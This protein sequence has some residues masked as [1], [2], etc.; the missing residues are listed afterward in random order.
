MYKTNGLHGQQM[1]YEVDVLDSMKRPVNATRNS[2]RNAEGHVA[3]SRTVIAEEV[4]GE[5]SHVLVEIPVNMLGLGE[6]QL[7]AFARVRLAS[8]QGE[9]AAEALVELPL[10]APDVAGM[11]GES[12]Y[13]ASD[14]PGPGS[15]EERLALGSGRDSREPWADES[16]SRNTSKRRK[17]PAEESPGDDPARKAPVRESYADRRSEPDRSRED[18]SSPEPSRSPDDD[19]TYWSPNREPVRRHDDDASASSRKNGAHDDRIRHEAARS[20]ATA[21]PSAKAPVNP[22]VAEIAE[23]ESVVRQSPNDIR[24]QMRLRILFLAERREADALAPIAGTD[25][26]T[27][28]KIE[29]YLAA[30]LPPVRSGQVDPTTLDMRELDRW[31]AASR[32]AKQ[33]RIPVAAFCRSIDGFGK[34][35]PFTPA[36]FRADNFPRLLIYLEVENFVSTRAQT[37]VYRTLLSVQ[38]KLLNSSGVEVWSTLDQEI[39]DLSNGLRKDFFLAIGPIDFQQVLP[40]DEYTLVISLRDTLGGGSCDKQMAFRIT[41]R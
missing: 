21:E 33:L 11:G 20:D 12:A 38:Q 27:Q 2:Y 32:D 1:L 31:V 29:E 36:V 15:E 37:G 4:T 8:S 14:A 23:L 10:K 25:P 26:S 17:Q 9:A 6:R 40:V 5:P 39:P 35:Q 18:T 3:G 24:A 13:A 19:L 7:P 34:Y 41:G 30:I 16:E 22:R 28:I